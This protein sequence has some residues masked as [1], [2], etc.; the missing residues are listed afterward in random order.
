MKAVS[1][2]EYNGISVKGKNAIVIGGPTGIG[3]AIAVGL[4]KEGANVVPTNPFR[5]EVKEAVRIVQ[6]LG[7]QSFSQV[8]DVTKVKELENLRDETVDKL[9][10]IDILVNCAGVH[11]KKPAE[12]TSQEEWDYIL[13]VQL[14]GAFNACKIIGSQ[15]IKRK[16]GK[17]INIGSVAAFVG[18]YQVAAYSA[19]KGGVVALTRSLAN[20]WAKYNINVNAIIP[21]F[22]LTEMNRELLE[23]NPKRLNMILSGTPMGRLGTPQDLVGA[24]VFLASDASDFVTGTTLIVDGGFLN[25][26]PD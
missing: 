2:Y 14:K 20:E 5:E 24:A 26:R 22:I 1:N 21:G 3:R 7:A 10:G 15:M 9:G 8:T 23:N 6:Q 19:A 11:L 4:A 13:D 16:R 12:E 25:T 18:L 17:I